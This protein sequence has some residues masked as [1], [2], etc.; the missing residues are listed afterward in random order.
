MSKLSAIIIFFFLF[1]LIFYKF[2]RVVENGDIYIY[3]R[4]LGIRKVGPRS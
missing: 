4:A 1:L 3:T 2:A